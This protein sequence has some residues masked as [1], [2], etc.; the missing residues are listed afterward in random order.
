MFNKPISCTGCPLYEAPYGKPTGFS[1]PTGSGSVLV[2][3]EALGESEE[4]E[5]IAL[6]GKAGVYTFQNLGRVGI[7]REQ[8][9]LFNACA[10]RPPENRLA[11]A[12][13][14]IGALAHCRSNLTAAINQTRAAATAAGKN[15]VILTLGNIA[16]RQVLRLGPKDPILKQD[17]YCYPVWSEEW[18]AWVVG[19]PHPSFLMRGK[20]NLVP[21]MQYAF[22]RAL[23]ISEQGLERSEPLYIL[24]PAPI[25]LKQWRLLY[26]DQLRKDPTTPLVYDI[27]TA[28]KQKVGAED[29]LVKD[30]DGDHRI[31]R[32]SFSFEAGHAVSVPWTFDWLG[33]I[34]AL[35][36]TT[37]PLVGWN[38]R[39]Y[40]DLRVS[41]ALGVPVSSIDAMLA[42]HVLN[43][44][45][46]KSLGF[47]APFYTTTELWKHLADTKPSFYN[48][49]DSDITWQLYRGIRSDLERHALWPV[50][51]RHIIQYD[52]ALGYMTRQGVLRDNTLRDRA[53]SELSGQLLTLEQ[54]MEVAVPVQAKAVKTRKLAPKDPQRWA[55]T[56]LPL[57]Q[58][59]CGACGLWKPTKTHA[60]HC[61]A[62]TVTTLLTPQVV[63]QQPLPFKLSKQSL[64]RYQAV[65]RQRPIRDRKTK[66]TTFDEAAILKLLSIY[67]KD[68]LYPQ[69][70][71]FRGLQKLLGTY[72]GV[73]V[74]GG[75]RGGMPISEDGRIHCQ[76]SHNPSTLRLS[77]SNPNMQNLPR[78]EGPEDPATMI[79]NLVVAAPGTVLEATDFSGIE[80]MLVGYF[81]KAP[82]FIRLAKKDVHTFFTAYALYDQGDR[83]V[84][85]SDLPELGWSDDKLFQSLAELKGRF[86]H[87]RNTTYKHLVHA[88]DFG[89]TPTG[90]R[91]KI[92]RD[93]GVEHPVQTIARSQG[94]YFALFPEIQ[95]WQGAL[96]QQAE[97]DGFLKNPFGYIHRF[98]RVFDYVRRGNGW[99]PKPGDDANRV[100]AFLPQST[101]AGIIA[102]AIIR[103]YF[104]RFE[105]AG[106]YLRL[107]VHDEILSEVPEDRLDVALAVKREEMGRPVPELPLPS[108]WGMGDHLAIGVESKTGSRWGSM[109]EV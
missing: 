98:H 86:K 12:P 20:N 82:Q 22:R 61:P 59:Y 90:A 94:T 56:V 28:Y 11:G 37:G 78:P 81:A 57:P 4:A 24:D 92:F 106:Q 14:E 87:E 107:Q 49:K 1:Y 64:E 41:T 80:A 70:L 42:W 34:T 76:F 16:F 8:F 102:E 69:I 104:T 100:L 88:F 91:D 9:T 99:E 71:Q 21:V 62:W 97:R 60:K 75:I 10:C 18:S 53:E 63:W 72:I 85:A 2:V 19:C 65:Q 84:L 35:L 93:T 48:A 17:F 39:S 96:L 55:E 105:D 25:T 13:Y 33:E 43:S 77:S 31:L 45:L 38:S 95:A 108:A 44:A 50:F 103:L 68:P 89:Q 5:G 7:T 51:E 36:Q 40:D 66:K 101:A 15:L 26:E 52:Q 29:L 6:V 67:P 54:R 46:P 47:V 74:E 58:K 23:E 79:R 27:E 73:T 109:K 32:V 3:A 83:R 30:E